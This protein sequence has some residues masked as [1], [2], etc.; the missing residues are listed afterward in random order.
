MPVIDYAAPIV[1][2]NATTRKI[3][4]SR[5][6]QQGIA[7]EWE[8][9]GDGD[10]RDVQQVSP[11]WARD[12]HFLRAVASGLLEIVGDDELVESTR[13]LSLAE[14]RNTANEKDAMEAMI[15]SHGG[16]YVINATDLDERINA[17]SKQQGEAPLPAPTPGT[18]APGTSI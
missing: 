15:E 6:G 8:S 7:V 5:P 9:K 12:V 1:V 11:D 18:N 14:K 3:V 10:G 2:R 13:R 17:M 16:E 4:F